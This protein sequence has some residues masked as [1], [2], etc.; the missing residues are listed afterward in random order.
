MSQAIDGPSPFPRGIRGSRGVTLALAAVA[1]AVLFGNAL[2][3]AWS[4]VPPAPSRTG[5]AAPPAGVDQATQPE[6]GT[7]Q[8]DLG[9]GPD[10]SVSTQAT[11][12]EQFHYSFPSAYEGPNSFEDAAEEEHTF[13]FSLFL[14]RRL[15]EG[16]ELFFDPEFFQ[17]YGLSRTLGIAGFP[18]GEAVKAGFANLHYNTSRLFIRE[19]FGFGGGKETL[20]ADPRQFAGEEDVNRLVFSVG[21]FS[22]SDFFDDNAYSHD[23]RSQFMN[24]A[25]WESAAWDYPAD[26]VGF[27]EGAVAEW[28]VRNS[29]LHYGVFMEP[30]ESNGARVDYHL[31]EAHGQIFQYDLRYNLG[32]RAGTLR[33][34]VYWNQARMGS[35]AVAAQQ[36]DPEDVILTRSYRSKV[37]LGASWDQELT[38]S[39]GAFVRASW[40]DGRTE[41][42]TFT[43]VDRSIAGGLSIVGKSWGRG[44]DTAG[45]A[46]AVNGLSA[47]Q[48][49][50]LEE[51]G[52]G[53]ILGDGALS[54]SPEEILE[55]YYMLHPWRRL[56]IGPDFQYIRNPGYN[57]VRGPVPVYA[58]RAH[59]EY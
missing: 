21:K 36:P 2:P 35:Y 59:V 26:I 7:L 5:A 52:T 14:G 34:F 51:G 28:S 43:E 41:S 42:F 12:I 32:G 40:D 22:A 50:Y 46:V 57:S 8:C 24:W 55:A 53:L 19:A 6:A 17:G 9:L 25:L 29:T 27:T 37:G 16:G 54:Y 11:Y 18:N 4:Q 38:E 30:Q 58:I 20:E 56:Q 49:H 31:G 47:N 33:S 39:I 13:S 45:I 3:T 15:W 44:A 10:W 23:P 1:G 48:R